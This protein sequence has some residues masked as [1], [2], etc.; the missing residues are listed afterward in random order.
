MGTVPPVWRS[1]EVGDPEFERVFWGLVVIASAALLVAF[2][3]IIL[4]DGMA[5]R[6]V[7]SF[8]LGLLVVVM[9]RMWWISRPGRAD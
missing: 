5:E 4:L 3:A 9:A 6:A 8:G 7:T 2:G 1:P